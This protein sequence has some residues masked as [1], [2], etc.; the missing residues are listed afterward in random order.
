MPDIQLSGGRDPAWHGEASCRFRGHLFTPAGEFLEGPAALSHWRGYDTGEKLAKRLRGTGGL[1]SLVIQNGS[2][3]LLASD[4]TG[5]FPLFYTRHG[6]GWVVS[7]DPFML[8]DHPTKEGSGSTGRLDGRALP[9]FR[10]GGYTIGRSTLL[11]G[12]FRVMPGELVVLG[13]AETIRRQTWFG[14]GPPAKQSASPDELT[15]EL[16]GLLHRLGERLIASLGGRTAVVPLSGGFDSRL[17]ACLLKRGGH[18]KVVCITYGHRNRETEISRGVA[19]RLGYPWIFTDYDQCIPPGFLYDPSFLAYCHHAGHASSMPY[20]QEY[21]S[22]YEL[23]KKGLVPEDSVFLPG[24]PGDNLG[25]SLIL[26]GVKSKRGKDRLVDTLINTF[27]RFLQL[28]PA[29]RSLLKSQVHD[30]LIRMPEFEDMKGYLPQVEQWNM[31][32]RLPKFI[33]NSARV[34]TWFGYGLRLPLWEPELVRFFSELP[35]ELRINKRLYDK[36]LKEAFFL[37]QGVFFGPEELPRETTFCLPDPVKRLGRRLVP[38]PLIRR[39]LTRRDLIGYA[40]FTEEMHTQMREAGRKV[41]RRYDS[42][43]ALLC[44]WYLY[45]LEREGI[46]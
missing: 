36:V 8:P 31:A 12:I 46:S 33:C 13:G 15:R 43:N 16:E 2:D 40:R 7:D 17:I 5:M 28:P 4:P 29:D 37:P 3:I 19:E 9:A 21:F 23:K 10:S 20:L 14:F 38:F 24:H 1:Y 45:L 27:F 42:F 39:R 32:E 6:G 25:G 44:E 18:D 34:F 30:R 41:P 11:E 22:V 26:K 35:Y